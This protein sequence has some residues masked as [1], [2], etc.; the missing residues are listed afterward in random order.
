MVRK[1]PGQEQHLN[2]SLHKDLHPIS[3]ENHTVML[4]ELLSTSVVWQIVHQTYTDLL[5][6][7]KTQGFGSFISQVAVFT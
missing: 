3:G 2:Y 6:R 1:T 7:S 5:E 4:K